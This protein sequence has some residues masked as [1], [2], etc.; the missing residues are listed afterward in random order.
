MERSL[1]IPM[2]PRQK[3]D[4]RARLRTGQ[5]EREARGLSWW[6]VASGV[7]AWP[8]SLFLCGQHLFLGQGDSGQ[9]QIPWWPHTCCHSALHVSGVWCLLIPHSVSALRGVAGSV[10]THIEDV[11]AG[12]K[13]SE[14]ND[15]SAGNSGWEMVFGWA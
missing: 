9:L 6:P 8:L 15:L 14:G 13:S 5:E 12:N 7:L 3:N 10:G 2:K 11:I 4:S 1:L